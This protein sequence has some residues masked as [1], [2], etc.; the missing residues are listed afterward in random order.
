MTPG[1][2]KPLSPAAY[3]RRDLFDTREQAPQARLMCALN[4]PNADHGGRYIAGVSEGAGRPG[5]CANSSAAYTRRP[6]GRNCRS[7]GSAAAAHKPFIFCFLRSLLVYAS[8][9]LPPE[10][11]SQFRCPD[12]RT[13]AMQGY[14]TVPA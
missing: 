14:A 1:S 4:R 3:L 10:H 7:Y 8:F 12:T 5:P 2:T 9:P 11:S 13:Y 6:I